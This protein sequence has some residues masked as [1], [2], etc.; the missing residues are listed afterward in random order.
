ML[1]VTYI[2]ILCTLLGGAVR[3]YASLLMTY[4]IIG[5]RICC[6]EWSHD[7]WRQRS[8]WRHTEEV[9]KSWCLKCVVVRQRQ[10]EF[11]LTFY[12]SSLQPNHAAMATSY[13]HQSI[14]LFSSIKAAHWAQYIMTV[15]A[16]ITKTDKLAKML[17][18]LRDLRR[19]IR[20]DTIHFGPR[21][22][23]SRDILDP[24]PKC[25]D[26]LNPLLWVRSVSGPKCSGSEL[27]VV[28]TTFYA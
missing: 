15:L 19:S 14:N 27:S 17:V 11:L 8:L 1:A 21:S 5:S 20:Q 3:R 18:M 22:E 9:M 24:S 26:T 12:Y 6:I 28:T 10:C 25:P 7:R 16:E 2:D 13:G 4:R 23:V